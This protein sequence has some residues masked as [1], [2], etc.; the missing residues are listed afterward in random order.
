MDSFI[1]IAANS[2]SLGNRKLVYGVGTNDAWYLT[3][4]ITDGKQTT[5][6]YYSSWRNM[7][8]RCYLPSFLDKRPTYKGC[9]VC[10]DWLLFSTFRSWMERQEWRGMVLDKDLLI[11][12]NKV[13]SPATCLFITASLNNLLVDSAATRGDYPQGVSLHKATGK[14]TAWCSIDAVR[15]YLGLFHRVVDAEVAYLEFKSE[16]VIEL[17]KSYDLILRTALVTYANKLSDKANKLK[18]S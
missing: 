16:S 14:F 7:L 8:K 5:C 6:P 10:D 12:G 2:N 13:Y 9:S 18:E 3:N 15:N 1:E 11:L 17:S 4:K